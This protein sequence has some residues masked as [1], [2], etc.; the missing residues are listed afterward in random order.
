MTVFSVPEY[1]GLNSNSTTY[2]LYTLA[3]LLALFMS[4][5]LSYKIWQILILTSVFRFLCSCKET[6][7]LRCVTRSLPITDAP[8]ILVEQVLVELTL[9][10]YYLFYKLFF[11][12]TSSTNCIT[13]VTFRRLVLCLLFN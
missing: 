4:G 2:W 9:S 8:L 13:K 7:H 11:L 5:F 6:V 10:K 12:N 3:G 1:Q